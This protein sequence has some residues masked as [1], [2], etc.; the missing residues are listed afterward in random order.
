[1]LVGLGKRE[2]DLRAE[3]QRPWYRSR[4]E[5]D[6]LGFG[7]GMDLDRPAGTLGS[8]LASIHDKKLSQLLVIA[9]YHGKMPCRRVTRNLAR[10]LSPRRWTS[11]RLVGCPRLAAAAGRSQIEFPRRLDAVAVALHVDALPYDHDHGR[12]FV[13]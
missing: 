2:H 10:G 7:P 4:V 1:R 3:A 8:E 12:G 9:S 6:E 13:D 5:G 11:R